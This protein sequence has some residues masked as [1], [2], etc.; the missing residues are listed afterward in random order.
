MLTLIYHRGYLWK[1]FCEVL[2]WQ[3]YGKKLQ[4]FQVYVKTDIS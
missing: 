3:I 2:V 4:G 1:A